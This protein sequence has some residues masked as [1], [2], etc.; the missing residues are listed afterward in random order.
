MTSP[1]IRALYVGYRTVYSARCEADSLCHHLCES[2]MSGN[3]VDQVLQDYSLPQLRLVKREV[4]LLFIWN[5][6]KHICVS[7]NT[8]TRFK[9]VECLCSLSILVNGAS[10]AH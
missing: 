7:S 3:G 8:Q 4:L 1:S 2:Q 6:A 9:E 5:F 10:G